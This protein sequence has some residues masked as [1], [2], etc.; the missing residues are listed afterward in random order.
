MTEEEKKPEWFDEI[1]MSDLPQPKWALNI[2]RLAEETGL[3]HA[4]LARR[5][6]MTRDS[7][8]R[9]AT[10]KTRPPVD[11]VH[12]LALLFGVTEE[13]ID[14]TRQYPRKP[15][16]DIRR[17]LQPYTLSPPLSGDP[18]MIHLKLEMDVR[19]GKLSGIL[20]LVAEEMKAALAKKA[21]DDGEA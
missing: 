2:S 17:A 18:D 1:D 9:Y 6:G 4:E 21:D 11:K 15:E 5:A 16:R 3:S 20:E 14:P 12:A 19:N 10:G 13:E 7:F 8:H